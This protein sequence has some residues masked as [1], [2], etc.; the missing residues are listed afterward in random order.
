[1]QKTYMVGPTLRSEGDTIR[2]IVLRGSDGKE[3]LCFAIQPAN[4]TTIAC[5]RLQLDHHNVSF[6]EF[7]ARTAI[8]FF[9]AGRAAILSSQAV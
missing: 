7:S 8:V 1:M 4:Y 2:S 6:H 3:R 5:T 9:V